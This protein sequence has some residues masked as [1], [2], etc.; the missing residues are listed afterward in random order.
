MTQAIGD[1]LPAAVGVAL[2]PLPIVA[3]V[4]MLVSSRGRVNGSAFLLGWIVGILVAGAILL[5]VGDA[6]GVHDD[7]QPSDS[8]SWVKLALGAG[9][10][11]M[12][13]RQFR[14]RPHGDE[15]PVTPKWMGALDTFSPAKAA[16]AGAALSAVNPKN[17]LLIAAGMAA[18]GQT[19]IPGDEQAVV[20]VLFAL[21]ASIGVAAPVVISF[22]MGD[23]SAAILDRLRIWMARNNP[24]IIAVVLLVIGVKL[25]GDA[26]PGVAN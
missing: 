24:V 15:E 20:L 14:G 1:M 17:L 12:A 23:R 8:V 26:L 5:V 10:L 11:S 18:I 22:A 7:G 19:G 21:V 3:T 9:L 6:I 25:I 16:V 4:L 2:S 13:L